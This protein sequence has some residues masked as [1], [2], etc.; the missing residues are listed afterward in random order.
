MSDM[1]TLPLKLIKLKKEI[2]V[3][4]GQKGRRKAPLRRKEGRKFKKKRAPNE[5]LESSRGC[6]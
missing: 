6:S 3:E 1:L 2:K 4:W 5:I